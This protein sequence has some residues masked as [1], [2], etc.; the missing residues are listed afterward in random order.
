MTFTVDGE[1]C[2]VCP[3]CG[4]LQPLKDGKF[5]Y[6]TVA[7]MLR[8]NCYASQRTIMEANELAKIKGNR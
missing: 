6:H 3:I 1:S 8:Q 5:P 7:P 4:R 2:P